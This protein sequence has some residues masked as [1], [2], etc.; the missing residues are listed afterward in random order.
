[1][2]GISHLVQSENMHILNDFN[3]KI[4]QSFVKN[5]IN[6]RSQDY[7]YLKYHEILPG[8]LHAL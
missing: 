3:T 8:L 1:M 5:V 6:S 4:K 2:Q 7:L